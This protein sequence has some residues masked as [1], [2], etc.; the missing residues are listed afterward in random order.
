MDS[1]TL[2]ESDAAEK[3]S[4]YDSENRWR[5]AESHSRKNFQLW[6]PQI[7]LKV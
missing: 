5:Y 4:G 2:V 6:G 1:S 7:G 3:P